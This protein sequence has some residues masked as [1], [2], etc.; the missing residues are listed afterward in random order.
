MKLLQ[1]FKRLVSLALYYGIAYYLP[2]SY[3]LLVGGLCNKIR[4]CLCKQI[5]KKAGNITTINRH[6]SFGGGRFVEIGDGSG[7]GA[8]A[9]LPSNIIIGN[10]VMMGACIEIVYR[11]HNFDR[12]DT[13]MCKQGF[14]E[15]KQ[16][17]IEDDCWIGNH[18]LFTPGRHVSKGT[19]VGLGAVLTK[20]F[21]SYS[22]VGGNPAHLIRQRKN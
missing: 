12:T 4:V 3:T 21:P 1:K 7:I 17:I 10:N 16:T 13:P 22:I 11:N 20:D 15:S 5:F 19:I 2:D 6:A 8:Y 9:K 14:S 18:V